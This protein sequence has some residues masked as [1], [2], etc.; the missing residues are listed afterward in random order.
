[1]LPVDLTPRTTVLSLVLAAGPFWGSP[2]PPNLAAPAVPQGNT[3]SN[4]CFVTSLYRDLLGRLPDSTELSNGLS[5]LVSNGR[6]VYASSLLGSDGYRTVLIQGF[7]QR[8]L[9]RPASESEILAAIGILNGPGTDEPVIALLTGSVEYFN[10][11]RVGADNTQFIQAVYQ[12]L[13]GRPALPADISIWLSFLGSHTRQELVT[14]ILS[15]MEY[16][17]VIIRAWYQTYLRRPATILEVNTAQSSL[18]G[19]STDEQVV[20]SIL[21]ATEYFDGAGRCATYLPLVRR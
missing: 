16:R 7:Y 19:G 20:A 13:L 17:A 3:P 1:M 10:Q 5:F 6:A 21:G 14:Q 12:D 15:S 2:I 4:A 18:S 9:G 11:A 8:F